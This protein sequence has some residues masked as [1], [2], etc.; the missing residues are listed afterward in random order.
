MPT[1]IQSTDEQHLVRLALEAVLATLDA[2]PVPPD[3]PKDMPAYL[4]KRYRLIRRYDPRLN[5]LD[6]ETLTRLLNT[7][8][9]DD[10]A[11]DK[12][13]DEPDNDDDDDD[14]DGEHGRDHGDE[15]A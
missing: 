6:G 11:D 15:A 4:A 8:L 13:D 2:A 10:E 12:A 1:E 5:A 7:P 14:D 9:E 3:N